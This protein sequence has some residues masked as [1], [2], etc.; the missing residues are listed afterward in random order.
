MKKSRGRASGGRTSSEGREDEREDERQSS[1]LAP[2]L[3]VVLLS[4]FVY[5]LEFTFFTVFS[6]G[7]RT[8]VKRMNGEGQAPRGQAEGRRAERKQADRG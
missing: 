8:S 5:L 6:N 7:G 2:F 3:P 4:F 1:P